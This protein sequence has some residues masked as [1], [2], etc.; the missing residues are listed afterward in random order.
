MS[1]KTAQIQIWIFAGAARTSSTCPKAPRPKCLMISKSA[2]EFSPRPSTT[3]AEKREVRG[4]RFCNSADGKVAQFQKAS[5]A[6]AYGRCLVDVVNLGDISQQDQQI[7]MREANRTMAL[8]LEQSA[9]K[10]RQQL[11]QWWRRVSSS[12]NVNAFPQR[13]HSASSFSTVAVPELGTNCDL[14]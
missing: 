6:N 12:Q 2:I 7:I 8:L 10:A 4:G 3:S 9:Q 11:R 14:R 5:V 13:T 1:K